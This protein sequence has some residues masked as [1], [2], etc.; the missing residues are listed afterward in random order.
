VGDGDGGG[1]VAGVE[2]VK[3]AADVGVDCVVADVIMARDF[4]FDLP[5]SEQLKDFDF[6]IGEGFGVF[7]D[8][9]LVSFDGVDEEVGDGGVNYGSSLVNGFDAANKS[10]HVIGFEE[11]AV[12]SQ[13]YGA[14]DVT[15]FIG[16]TKDEDFALRAVLLDE[17][18]G[19]K[20][21][22]AR[23]AQVEEDEVGFF[24]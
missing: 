4:L 23:E 9:V 17:G 7:L 11:I 16:L 22:H 14:E 8:F 6:A 18:K 15:L 13:G 3:D 19:F 5:L 1:G 12:S 2:L 20:S 21:A 24:E 10:F